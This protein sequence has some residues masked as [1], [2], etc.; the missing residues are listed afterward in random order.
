MLFRS[1]E[2][3][4]SREVKQGYD[5]LM[6]LSN[7][8]MAMAETLFKAGYASV[9]DISESTDEDLASVM[10][11]PIED[12]QSTIEESKQILEQERLELIQKR[13][14]REQERLAKEQERQAQEQASAE[15]KDLVDTE[16]TELDDG[17]ED[18]EV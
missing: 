16:P 9:L 17:I 1:S 18:A 14:D 7:V 8:G 2:E 15:A 11:I 12:A 4:Y 5:S 13:L 10:A 3:D 6:K